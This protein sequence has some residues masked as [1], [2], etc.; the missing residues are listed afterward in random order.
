MHRVLGNEY[1]TTVVC[2]DS[3]QDRVLRG[4]LYNLMLNGAVPFTGFIE[5]LLAMETILD[6]MNFPQPFTA[7]RSFRP[8][9]KTLPPVR[10]E[11][12]EQQGQA[13]TFSIKVIFRQN[14]SWQGTVAWLEEGREESFR[15]VLELGMLFNSAL[16]DTGQSDEYELRKTSPP[17]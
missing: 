9:D 2:I 8:V 16:T 3:Y 13:A 6:Q 10:T 17:I 7:E 5:F 4:R 12:M 14:A 1:H 15:S 11:N